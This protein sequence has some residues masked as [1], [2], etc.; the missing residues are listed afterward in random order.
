[1]KIK[2]KIYPKEP[3]YIDRR[4]VIYYVCEESPEERDLRLKKLVEQAKKN[5]IKVRRVSASG[6]TTYYDSVQEAAKASGSSAS[7]VSKCINGKQN[8]CMG[9]SFYKDKG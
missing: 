1:M 2:K 8:S 9:Y 5:R 3:T 7:S 4:K 6:T